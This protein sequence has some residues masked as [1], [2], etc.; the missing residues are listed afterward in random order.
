MKEERAEILAT[1]LVQGVGFR[2]FVVRKA[3]LL[4]LKGYTQNLITGDVLTVAEGPKAKLEEL[5]EQIKIG[6]ISAH[7]KS[8]NVKWREATGEFNNFEVRY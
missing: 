5:I 2:Y 6:P 1:G 7:V 3:A 4:D 8:V